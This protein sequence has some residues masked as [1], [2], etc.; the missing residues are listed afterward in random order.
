[1]MSQPSTYTTD[2]KV[3]IHMPVTRQRKGEGPSLMIADML[4]LE[5]G[6]LKDGDE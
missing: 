3:S 1:M 6:S 4:T 2:A 5:W